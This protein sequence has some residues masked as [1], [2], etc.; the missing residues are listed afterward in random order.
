MTWLQMLFNGPPGTPSS[1]VWGYWVAAILTI[2]IYSFLYKDNPLYKFAESLFVGVGAAYWLALLYHETIVPKLIQPLFMPADGAS[3]AWLRVFPGVLAVFMLLRFYP[4]LSW[5]SR[6][7]LGFIVGMYSA[8]NI[9]GF[10]QGD[11]VAQIYATMTTPLD[12]GGA[13]SIVLNVA[14]II[15]VFAVLTYFFFSKEHTGALGGVAKLGIWFL[16]VAFGASFGYTVMARVS[17]LIG[18]MQFLLGD[19]LHIIP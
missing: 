7:S 12:S 5:L 13:L 1:V 11:F 15:G 14:S 16:M 18:R 10:A 17:L 3:I 4:K 2:C 6:W 19:W 9:T 8:V